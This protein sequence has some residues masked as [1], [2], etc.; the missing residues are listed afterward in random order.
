[1]LP[2]SLTSPQLAAAMSHPTRGRVLTI[3]NDR[4]ASP[5]EVAD[6]IGEPL[7][8]VAYH[9][10]ILVKLGCIELVRAKQ[11]RGGRVVEHFYR[12]IE[13]SFFTEDDW[14]KIG[15]EEQ[16]TVTTT[17]MRMISHDVNAAMV[18]GTFFDDDNHLSRTPFSVDRAGWEEI[19]E[20]LAD[21]LDRLLTIKEN[22][23]ARGQ[24]EDLETFPARVNI[25]HYRSP[26]P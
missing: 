17:I 22:V 26:G 20:V 10:K 14:K 25:I 2:P 5:R 15:E 21:A 4:V 13:P 8:N 18:S 12:A 3:L 9:I 24:R 1:M 16:R 7:N 23:A 6:E 11:S 19:K